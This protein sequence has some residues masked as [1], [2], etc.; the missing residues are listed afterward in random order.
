MSGAVSETGN[1]INLLLGERGDT[2]RPPGP[3][4]QLKVPNRLI[5]SPVQSAVSTHCVFAG[6]FQINLPAIGAKYLAVTHPL[7][8]SSESHWAANTAIIYWWWRWC[9]PVYNNYAKQFSSQFGV[10]QSPDRLQYLIQWDTAPFRPAQP[11][12]KPIRALTSIRMRLL[13]LIFF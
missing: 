1:M 11:G 9:L 8:W 5:V 7:H 10:L 12:G 6:I 2:A 13:I 3:S 4:L